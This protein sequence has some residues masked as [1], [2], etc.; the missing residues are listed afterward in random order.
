MKNTQ[1]TEN[2]DRP[3]E[4]IFDPQDAILSKMKTQTN[5]HLP[6]KMTL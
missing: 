1:D 5:I 2:G 4:P 6:K 3:N